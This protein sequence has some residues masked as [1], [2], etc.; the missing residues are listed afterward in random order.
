MLYDKRWDTKS[1]PMLNSLIAWLEQQNPEIEYNYCWP[2]RCL[3]AQW[4]QS[5]GARRYALHSNEVRALF[6]GRGADVIWEHPRTF[7]A[8][9][10]RAK[11]LQP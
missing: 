2:D 11:A 7:G 5:I 8:A 3:A 6:G 10:A 9:L 4:L 1:D